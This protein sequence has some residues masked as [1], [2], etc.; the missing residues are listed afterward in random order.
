MFLYEE[1]Q[2]YNETDIAIYKY[3]VKN[4]NKIQYM[5]IRELAKEIH[6]SPSTILRFC[7][8]NNFE[9]YSEFK[10]ALKKERT[11]ENSYPPMKDLQELSEFFVKANS[12]AFEE[13]LLFAVKQIQKAE[14]TEQDISLIWGTLQWG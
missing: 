3:I 12:S 14:K 10:E 5:S 4:S 6:V 11:L 2:K 9:R 1:I 13:K 7:N 8:K